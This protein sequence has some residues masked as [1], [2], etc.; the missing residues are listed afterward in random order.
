MHH[1]A[2]WQKILYWSLFH[3][4]SAGD[5]CPEPENK[6]CWSITSFYSLISENVWISAFPPHSL[7]AGG[8]VR[9]PA[10]LKTRRHIWHTTAVQQLTGSLVDSPTRCACGLLA[11]F[12]AHGRLICK[13][14]N[15]LKGDPCMTSIQFHISSINHITG[16]Q[17]LWLIRSTQNSIS[18]SVHSLSFTRSDLPLLSCLLFSSSLNIHCMSTKADFSFHKCCILQLTLAYVWWFHMTKRV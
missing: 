3:S 5:P 12:R 6:E 9:P 17:I 7:P 13:H 16:D 15:V 8:G 1:T 10:V 11:P 4:A 18:A 2:I 14:Q